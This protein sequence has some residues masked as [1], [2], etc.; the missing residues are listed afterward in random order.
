MRTLRT[1]KI[2]PDA[3]DTNSVWLNGDKAK[4]FNNGVWQT[5][6]GS[7]SVSWDNIQDKPSEYTPPKATLTKLGGI[8]GVENIDPLAED[9]AL[10]AVIGKVN[11]LITKLKESG[12]VINI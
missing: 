9:S 6:G 10:T 4:Y 8:K 11:E 12:V 5:I 2:S 1:L 3:P 7:D